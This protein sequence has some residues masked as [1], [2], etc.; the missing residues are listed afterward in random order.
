MIIFSDVGTNKILTRLNIRKETFLSVRKQIKN[1][2][3]MM[4]DGEAR[5]SEKFLTGLSNLYIYKLGILIRN[6][7]DTE[8]QLQIIRFCK[9]LRQKDLNNLSSDK[10][11]EHISDFARHVFFEL[12]SNRKHRG[13]LR[14]EEEIPL[15][16]IRLLGK[17]SF[18][19]REI[20]EYEEN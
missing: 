6:K 9:V 8:E 13:Y 10:M 15:D 17:E 14:S 2:L 20:E 4:I 16:L 12:T 3:D 11:V 19:V 7:I 18:D 1:I 5:L